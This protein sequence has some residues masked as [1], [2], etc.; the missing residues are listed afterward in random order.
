MQSDSGSD[1]DEDNDEDEDNDV[2]ALNNTQL[3]DT[4]GTQEDI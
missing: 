4:H 3:Q 1:N 2:P